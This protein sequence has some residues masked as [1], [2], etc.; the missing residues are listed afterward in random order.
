M[1]ALLPCFMMTGGGDGSILYYS[2]ALDLAVSVLANSELGYQRGQCGAFRAGD[3]ASPLTCIVR[4][5]FESVSVNRQLYYEVIINH[6]LFKNQ[7][8]MLDLTTSYLEANQVLS[9]SDEKNTLPDSVLH[10]NYFV[11]GK[12][13][14]V[15][16][17]S[18][19]R[20]PSSHSGSNSSSHSGSNSSSHS[21]NH[22]S[23]HSCNHS[24]SDTN[25][26]AGDRKLAGF[27]GPI[28]DARFNGSIQDA[29]FDGFDGFDVFS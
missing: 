6:K 1:L 4:E 9:S 22:S 29:R 15:H 12:W 5:L 17:H 2:P 26:N 25:G 14:P 24:S 19:F 28:K 20:D 13:R 3:T 23:S 10:I 21:C 11:W 7:Y 18:F 27:N 8:L 16:V